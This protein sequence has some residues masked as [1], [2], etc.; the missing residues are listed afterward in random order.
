[1]VISMDEFAVHSRNGIKQ[2][3]LLDFL[4]NIGAAS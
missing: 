4:N 2:V 1:M 3:H